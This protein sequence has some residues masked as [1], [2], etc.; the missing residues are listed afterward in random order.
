MI[1]GISAANFSDKID[2]GKLVDQDIA[3]SSIYALQDE[4]LKAEEDLKLSEAEKVKRRKMKKVKELQAMFKEI[5][6][7]NNAESDDLAKLTP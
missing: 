4:K 7:A 6:A 2:F 5:L 3:D 1:L